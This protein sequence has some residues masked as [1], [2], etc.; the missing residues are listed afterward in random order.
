MTSQRGRNA[1][2]LDVNNQNKAKSVFISLKSI[3]E[4]GLGCFLSGKN[5]QAL[6]FDRSI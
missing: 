4:D 6:E 1:P 5:C 3:Q 2:E